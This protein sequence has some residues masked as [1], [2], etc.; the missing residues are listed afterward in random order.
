MPQLPVPSPGQPIDLSYIYQIVEELN[1]LSDQLAPSR[2]NY[3][4]IDTNDGSQS[5][6]TSDARIVGG[7]VPL[8]TSASASSEG[9]FDFNYS[10]K[11]FQYAPIVTVTPI[12]LGDASADAG[13][14]ATVILTQVTTNSVQG[15]LRLNTTEEVA[16]G[17]NIVAVGIPA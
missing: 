15:I 9:D 8:S 6:K 5:V 17:L 2:A 14:D 12:L 16:I 1:R 11:E 13:K 7:F 10:F 4:N 3:T